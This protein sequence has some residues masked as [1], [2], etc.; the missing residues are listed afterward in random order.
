MNTKSFFNW[1]KPTRTTTDTE[2][3]ELR[4]ENA[5]LRAQIEKCQMALAVWATDAESFKLDAEEWK[6]AAAK[7]QEIAVQL[8]PAQQISSFMPWGKN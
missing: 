2:L 5:R 1:L 4:A 7:W 8:S 6:A 3:A